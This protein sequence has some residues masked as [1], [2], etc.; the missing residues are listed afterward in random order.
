MSQSHPN[1]SATLGEVAV[2]CE[3]RVDDQRAEITVSGVSTD[4]RELAA[5]EL[6]VALKGPHHD[7][8]DFLTEAQERGAAAAVVSDPRRAPGDLPVVAVGDTLKALGLLAAWHRAK[9]P[10]R[11]VAITGSTGKTSTKDMLGQIVQSVAPAVVAEGTRNNEIGVP[12]TLLGLSPRD[13]FCV[14]ELAMRGPGEIDYLAGIARPDVGVIT[15]IGQ[16]HV[17]K[18]GSREAI[19]QA[20]AELLEHIPTDGAAVLN[21]D[22]FFFSVFCAM[23]AAPVVSFGIHAEADFRALEVDDGDTG[24]VGFRMITPL[25]TTDVR[26]KVPGRHSVMN[27]LA[28]A[29]AA[30]QVGATLDEIRAALERHEGSPM[31]MQRLPGLRGAVILNDAY[32]ASPDSVGAALRVLASAGGRRVFVFG[33]MLE[34]GAEAESAHRDVGRAAAEAGVEWMIAVGELAALAADEAAERGVRVDRVD[35]AAQAA[36]LLRPEL[37]KNDVVLVKASR[38]MA[39]ERVAEALSDDN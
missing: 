15:N 7:A 14:L 25:G 35:E 12:L 2:A 24:S 34:L 9:M 27:A 10:A 31:R 23:A 11:V 13:R 4:T 21:A 3:G 22:D 6:F 38:G 5:G 19:A 20:K 28:A 18:L 32:N 1:F 36:E 8:H 26:M 30:S 16:S 39:L 37:T 29:A 33:D 17:G